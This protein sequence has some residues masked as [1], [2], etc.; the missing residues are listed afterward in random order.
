[1]N[2]KASRRQSSAPTISDVAQHA[3]VSPMTVSRVIN[4]HQT[5]RPATRERV[6][7]AIAK[8]NY[9]PSS[10]ARTLAGVKEVRIGLLY[11]NPSASY[12]SEFLMGS[13]DQASRLNVLLTVENF[14]DDMNVE[15]VI[16]HL[17]RARVSGVILPPPLCDSD[18]MLNALKAS[19]INTI[20]VASGQIRH[21]V[22]SVNIDD[23][24]AAGE[25][26]RH[27]LA[28]GHQRIGFIKGNP[29]ISASERRFAGYCD[30][31]A[32]AGVAF[33][34]SLVAQGLFTYRSGLDASEQ[35]LDQA[36]PPSAIFA[37]NDDMA[38]ATMAIAHGRGLDV[39][40][41]LTV[42]GFDD[43]P[44]A[45]AIWPELTTI[46]QPISDMARSAVDLLVQQ[47]RNDRNTLSVVKH[48]LMD[49]Q[50]VRRQSDTAPRR[51]PRRR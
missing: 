45:T 8:L 5:V 15:R 40:G 37:S 2:T 24:L 10:A 41:D 32:D 11:S 49:Y 51:K 35:I 43:T 3:G 13:L 9:E 17:H 31:L 36:D 22:S 46:R 14:S 33:D 1:M 23:Q 20:A 42:C 27:L 16:D 39:P 50:L 4:A 30:A 19:E 21:D 25:M 47:I 6:E 44:L 26:T 12:L 29:D 34:P 7:A 28:M 38:A 18:A 48:I